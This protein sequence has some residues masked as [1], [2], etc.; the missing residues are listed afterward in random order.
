MTDEM[1][2]ARTGDQRQV[3]K[4]QMSEQGFSRAFA[5][6]KS[7]HTITERSPLLPPTVVDAMIFTLESDSQ[8]A[9]VNEAVILADT[10]LG[11]NPRNEAHNPKV[12]YN[13]IVAIFSAYPRSLGKK[14]VHKVEGFVANHKF[15]IKPSDL[16]AFLDKALAERN[17][18]LMMAHRMKAEHKR[19]N[20]E[21][22]GPRPKL[23]AEQ[24]KAF[25]EA[26][27]KGLKPPPIF[28]GT[29]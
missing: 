12:F 5:I 22:E 6:L 9:T 27:M 10:L 29:K 3:S 21:D 19:R 18:A 23:N 11:Q 25:V 1:L 16:K 20:S 17:T 2:P 4:W 15:E 28:E 26:V 8:K 13:A 14:A 7:E 24:R